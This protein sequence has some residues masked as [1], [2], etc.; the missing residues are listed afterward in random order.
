MIAATAL[1]KLAR[2]LQQHQKQ[3]VDQGGSPCP[4][5]SSIRTGG[6]ENHLADSAN[7]ANS[8]VAAFA[9]PPPAPPDRSI[10]SDAATPT[11]CSQED[12]A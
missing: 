2:W 3:K 10:E 9:K 6:I 5:L 7:N 11:D 8:P 1:L 4:S 12:H